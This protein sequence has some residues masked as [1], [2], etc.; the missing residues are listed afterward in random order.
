MWCLKSNLDQCSSTHWS[1]FSGC[2]KEAVCH[3]WDYNAEG[4]RLQKLLAIDAKRSA[5][6]SCKILV[7]YKLLI[8][9]S[10]H[11]LHYN[12]Y[13]KSSHFSGH[14]P[15]HKQYSTLQ[16]Q[17]RAHRSFYWFEMGRSSEHQ[18]CC[19][20]VKFL[21]QTLNITTVTHPCKHNLIL[22]MHHGRIICI[23]MKASNI[24]LHNK[25]Q[26]ISCLF[27]TTPSCIK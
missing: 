8:G 21:Y 18:I 27:I 26:P 7:Q 1:Y 25:S 14:T 11:V 10:M 15:K 12:S 17:A 16:G 2:Y 4:F 23:E 3:S 9:F 19:L 13:F 6:V 20:H 5:E 24:L 22:L